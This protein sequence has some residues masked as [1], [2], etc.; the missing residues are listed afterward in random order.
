MAGAFKQQYESLFGRPWAVG[1]AAILV[2][3]INVFLFAF[4]RPWTASDGVRNW[5]DWVLTFLGVVRRPDLVAP[6]FYSGSLIDIGVLL[7]GFVAALLAREFAI[8]VP[9]VGELIKGGMGGT[10]MGTGAMLAFGCNIGGFFSAT[11]ALSLSGLG[12]MLGLLGRGLARAPLPALGDG[13][14]PRLVQRPGARSRSR[15]TGG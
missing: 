6:W 8:R 12:M 1:S 7:G 9:P 4:D 2:A 10:L 13:A 11:S 3:A 14:S 15:P 5:G